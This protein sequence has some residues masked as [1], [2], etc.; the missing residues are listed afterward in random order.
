MTGILVLFYGTGQKAL[1][2][3]LMRDVNP[4]SSMLPWATQ[5]MRPT[6]FTVRFYD[7]LVVIVM[8]VQGFAVGS[9]ID[10]IR[11]FRSREVG[12]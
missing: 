9:V 5:N 2:M 3:R 11:W 12:G 8:A 4:M 1:A 10:L 7:F 6:A